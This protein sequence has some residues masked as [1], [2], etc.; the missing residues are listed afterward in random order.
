MVNTKGYY[1]HNRSNHI[2]VGKKLAE[3]HIKPYIKLI[4]QDPIH[5]NTYVTRFSQLYSAAY[6]K[7]K[8]IKSRL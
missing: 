8:S 4:E 5:Q 6:Y 3:S 2:K 7:G 1:G